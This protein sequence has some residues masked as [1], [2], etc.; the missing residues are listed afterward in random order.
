MNA[1]D[2]PTGAVEQCKICGM[3]SELFDEAQALR[4]YDVKYFRCT[5]CGFLQTETPY[6]L[7][8]AYS[9]AISRLDTGILSRNLANRQLAST[10]LNLLHPEAKRCLDFGAGHGIFVRLMRDRGFEFSWYDLHATNDY[11]GGFEHEEGKTYDFLTSFEVLEHLVDPLAELSTMMSLSPNVF[12]S[13][14]LLPKPA[15]KVSDWWYYGL[16]HGQHVSLYT[17]DA[18]HS[19][20]HRFGRNLLSRG[21]YHLFT[22]AR[23]NRFL[24]RAATSQSAS[25]V[26]SAWRKRASLAESDHE[27]MSKRET[28]LS[29]LPKSSGV[30]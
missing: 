13:T 15:P 18:L 22:V 11:A 26:L 5:G 16:D 24:F 3:Q 6:W 25:Q 17:L 21:S 23:K 14:L 19:I 30:Q 10:V 7:T 1:T 29:P 20:A 27:L 4:K 2:N 9:T 12:V 8:E 28:Q